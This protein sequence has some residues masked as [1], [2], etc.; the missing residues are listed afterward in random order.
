MLL[1]GD[2]FLMNLSRQK[3]RGEAVQGQLDP[4]LPEPATL[5]LIVT[6]N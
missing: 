3:L 1:S 6:S 2:F 4:S 5:S